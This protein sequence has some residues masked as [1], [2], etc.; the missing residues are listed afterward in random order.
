MPLWW[1]RGLRAPERDTR[2]LRPGSCRSREGCPSFAR[3]T[4]SA[5]RID[6]GGQVSWLP[7]HRVRPAFPTSQPVAL[8]GQP[9]SGH[10]CGG[11]AG[12]STG[13]PFCF[14]LRGTRHGAASMPQRG[15][16][17]AV[18]SS[19]Q[20]SPARGRCRRR[21]R[22][23]RKHEGKRVAVRPLRHASRATSPWRGRKS[24]NRAH[25]LEFERGL[26]GRR[27]FGRHTLDLEHAD[28]G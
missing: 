7:G 18:W 17:Q 10:S 15:K 16:A 8:L 6:R 19:F 13:L 25:S 23:G 5:Q 27:R 2:T 28:L 21:R 1:G 22:K 20:S 3:H 4:P 14:P 24:G 26:C 9:L 11:S 12:I